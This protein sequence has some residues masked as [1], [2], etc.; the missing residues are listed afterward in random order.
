MVIT[1]RR[2]DPESGPEGNRQPSTNPSHPRGGDGG[3]SMGALLVDDV[4]PSHEKSDPNRH[5]DPEG[6]N[7]PRAGG[8]D[9]SNWVYDPLQGISFS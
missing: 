4:S 9:L 6:D 5:P 1:D 3:D 8:L 2:S 7:A